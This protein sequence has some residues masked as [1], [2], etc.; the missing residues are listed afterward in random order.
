MLLGTLLVLPSCEKN[1]GAVVKAQIN[2]SGELILIYGDGTEQNLGVV[3]GKDG[4]KGERGADGADGKDGV[5]GADGADG[6]DGKNGA[7]GTD[8]ADGSLL[9][10]SDGSS[11]PA[12]SAKGLRS[13]VSIVCKFTKNIQSSGLFPGSGNASTYEYSSA[14][15]GVIYQLDRAAGDAFI[16]TNYHVVYDASS[17]TE[18]G[19]SEEISV[20]LYGSEVKERA[21]KATYVGGS[22]YYDI[23]VLH[24]DN[25]DEI[26]KSDACEI[27]VADSDAVVVGD[28]AIAIGNA[29][30]YGI[31]ASF[32]VVSVDS[33]YIKMTAADGITNVSFRVMRIDTAVNSGNSGG[34]LYDHEGN[35]IGIVNAKIIDE[36]VENIGYAIPSN[37]AVSIADNIIDYCYG[38][39][40]ERVQRAILGITVTTSDSKAV[41]SAQ[42]GAVHIEETVSVYEVVEDSLVEG[43][44]QT[45][46]VFVSVSI[47]GQTARITRQHHVIDMMLDVRVGD[48]VTFT[49]LR[50]GTEKE[51]EIEI[52]EDCLT[53]Y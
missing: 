48:T 4:E 51:V 21:M 36:G 38:T 26:K 1:G 49:V 41:Y 6:A 17:N 44:L 35:L 42:T 25:S 30:G 47:N 31:S 15:S 37:V 8:G 34:G 50:S 27:D 46:D 29:K 12:A 19:I 14:G 45:G 13:A 9:I 20:Y 43:L 5:D 23:A 32:G 33:E 16:I 2:D 53:A 11:I 22:L 24:I 40:E 52:R 10:T 28:S 18:N 39:S 3:T 7:S